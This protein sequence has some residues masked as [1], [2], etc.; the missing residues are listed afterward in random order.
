MECIDVSKFLIPAFAILL[1][2]S[3]FSVWRMKANAI[4]G[5]D[6]KN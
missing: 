4:R 6:K 2:L 5:Y 3:W 1:L